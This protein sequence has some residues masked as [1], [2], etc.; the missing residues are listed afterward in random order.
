[1]PAPQGFL[2]R[3]GAIFRTQPRAWLRRLPMNGWGQSLKS[4]WPRFAYTFD[5]LLGQAETA[6]LARTQ[7]AQNQT[8]I[9][10][11]LRDVTAAEEVIGWPARY[12]AQRH[13]ELCLAVNCVALAHSLDRPAEWIVR[14]R[15]GYA[16]TWRQRH[17]KGCE[18]I[19]AAL[20]EDRVSVF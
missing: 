4:Y 9:Q 2:G 7:Q 3:S 11:S 14:K 18:I 13:P 8:R 20:I 5:D 16:D 12:L 10:P 6:E 15:G 1:M 17:D 19:A